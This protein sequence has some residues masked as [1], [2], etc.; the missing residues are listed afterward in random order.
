MFIQATRFVRQV[1]YGLWVYAVHID[2]I[3]QMG[4][5]L[6]TP[7]RH[8]HLLLGVAQFHTDLGINV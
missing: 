7:C 3:V 6:R 2:V 5:W 4:H 1:L 8:G